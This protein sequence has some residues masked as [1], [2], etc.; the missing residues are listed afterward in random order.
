MFIHLCINLYFV[1]NVYH[2]EANACGPLDIRNEV[3]LK[4]RDMDLKENVKYKID[5]NGGWEM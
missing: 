1:F 2:H 4:L 5:R 3:S